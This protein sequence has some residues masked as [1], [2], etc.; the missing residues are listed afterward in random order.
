MYLLQKLHKILM[1]LVFIVWP[2]VPILN[3]LNSA[4]L[5]T[6]DNIKSTA[7]FWCP[8]VSRLQSHSMV[9]FLFACREI[10]HN[11]GRESLK[12]ENLLRT[13]DDND[14]GNWSRVILSTLWIFP[15]KNTHAQCEECRAK[16][17]KSIPVTNA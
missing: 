15:Q 9:N 17:D 7:M 12:K 5:S 13:I 16:I 11:L 3:L 8:C 2:K 14:S 10:C 6:I 1:G 4:H